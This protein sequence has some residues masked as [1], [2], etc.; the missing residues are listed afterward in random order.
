MNLLT[1]IIELQ[2]EKVSSTTQ[3]INK[4]VAATKVSFQNFL[5]G[6]CA[7]TK[8]THP[9]GSVTNPLSTDSQAGVPLKAIQVL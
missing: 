7:G 5:S 9:T 8:Q 6:D 2:D 1:Y 4:R 3:Y